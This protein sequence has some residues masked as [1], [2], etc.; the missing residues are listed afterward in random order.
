MKYVLT[1]RGYR[2]KDCVS[3]GNS[4]LVG[5]GHFGYRGTLEEYRAS[6]Q[7]AWNLVG[8]YDQRGSEWRESFNLPNPFFFETYVDGNRETVHDC[9]PLK[10]EISLDLETGLF[11][12][13]SEFPSYLI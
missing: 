13:L 9:A 2:K 5:N 7:A 1:H 4:F 8:V 6:E 12:R 3:E 11:S 10:H